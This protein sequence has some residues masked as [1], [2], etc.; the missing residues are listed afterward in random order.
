[1]F[2]GQG[3]INRPHM[4]QPKIPQAETKAPGSQKKLLPVGGSGEG[5][6]GTM[7]DLKGGKKQPLM[8]SKKQA[9]EMGRG[10]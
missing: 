4:L 2:P 5:V 1:M 7:W 8:H 6:A 3:T 10:R 9:K